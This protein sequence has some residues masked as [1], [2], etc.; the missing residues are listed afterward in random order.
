MD[1]NEFREFGRAAIDFVADYLENIR[2]RPVLPSVQPGYLSEL[3]PTEM[4]EQ[5]EDWRL[6]MK[7]LESH[8][9]PGLTHWQSPNFH[10]YYPSQTSFPSIVGEMI[11]AGLGVVGFSWICS[12]ACTELEV[13]VMDWIGKFLNLPEVFL[14]SGEGNGGGI[15]QG[16]ASEAILIAVLAAREQKVR[17]I[18][19]D[20]P[21]MSDGDIRSKLVAYG[22]IHS[23]SAIEKSGLLGAIKMRLLEADENSIMRGDTVRKAIE[24]DIAAGLFPTCCVA[25]VGTTGT[26]AFDNLEEIG[27][28]CN[29]HNVWLHIDAAYAG[30]AFCLPEYAH[31]K[32]GCEMGDSVNFNL[33]KWMLV[34]F[35]CCAMWL[36]DAGALTESFNVD[37]IYLDHE[38]QGSSKAPDYRHWQLA[39][40]R[41]FRALRVWITLRTYGQEYI[42]TYVRKQIGLAKLFENFVLSDERFESAGSSLGLAFFRVRGSCVKTKELLDKISER[43]HIYMIPATYREKI[44]IRFC[45]CGHEPEE[46]DVEYAWNEIKTVAEMVL[47]K[48][49]TPLAPTAIDNTQEVHFKQNLLN[50]TENLSTKLILSANDEKTKQ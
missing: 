33:H 32:K 44:I 36:K 49:N 34:N 11:S 28:V 12:P 50:M 29:E 30:A 10:A 5:S 6:I 17:Q 1:V 26:C 43:K 45:I 13:I 46:K 31:I 15:I 20:H 7:D 2:D 47:N 22:S 25:T 40:G 23:N 38:Y 3:L 16:S 4:P 48:N 18:K 24:E 8:I 14:P 19:K 27:P 41:R 39:L 35:D 37:R 9:M 42:R 21:E